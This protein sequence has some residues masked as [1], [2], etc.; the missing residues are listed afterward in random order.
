MHYFPFDL[1]DYAKDTEHL[2][3]LEHGV[4]TMLLRWYYA[5]ERPIP[6]GMQTRITR[7][8][9][10]VVDPI[11]DEFFD[12]DEE[13][14][15]WRHKR[16]DKVIDDVHAKS[17][18]ARASAQARWG[19][20]SADASK[21]EPERTATS[22]PQDLKNSPK[23][24]K[25]AEGEK[26]PRA[27]A[28]R[29]HT[30]EVFLASLNEGQKAFPASDP[31]FEYARSIKLPILLV[32]LAWLTFVAEMRDKKKLQKDWRATFRTYVRK[33]Y[34]GLW[35]ASDNNGELEY[36]LTTRGKQAREQHRDNLNA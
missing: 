22:K 32:K 10:A 31:L 29:G 20:R 9:A 15:A 21:P 36:E 30:I 28:E 11:M 26:K 2:T 3:A 19:D 35:F 24:P 17:E 27:K 1:G 12:W 14:Q 7:E 25:G 5:N 6:L 13:A 4:Y 18:K 34:L 16:A 8:S 23:P 33:N